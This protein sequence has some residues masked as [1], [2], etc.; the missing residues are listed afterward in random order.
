MTSC[1]PLLGPHSPDKDDKYACV[2]QDG[3]SC[4][5]DIWVG[6]ASENGISSPPPL[7]VDPTYFTWSKMI[8]VVKFEQ[9]KKGGHIV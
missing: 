5:A 6:C 1:A 8:E 2:Y 4:P 7:D 9:V 3:V